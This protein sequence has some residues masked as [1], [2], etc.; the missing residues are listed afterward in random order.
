MGMG[1][2]DK[3]KKLMPGY[4][5]MILAA[6]TFVIVALDQYTKM[7]VHSSFELGE[8]IRVIQGF[9][10]LTYVRNVGAAFGI[11][12]QS[13]ETFRQIFFLSVPP[14]AVGIIIY[15]IYNLPD[16]E[17]S[18]IYALSFISGGA[19]GN[20]IDRLRF[21][22]V[23]DFMDFHIQEKYSWPAFNVADMAIVCG[24]GFLIYKMFRQPKPVTEKAPDKT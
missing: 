18:E 21:G 24:V 17:R 19:V 7:V 22:Y 20:Y 2:S 9:F 6:I 8:S 14:I 3:Q 10:N 4:K 5:Y 11:F 16:D 15:F 12:G 1:N 13:H 23:I